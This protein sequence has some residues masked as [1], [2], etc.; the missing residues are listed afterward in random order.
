M[1]GPHHGDVAAHGGR[2]AEVVIGQAARPLEFLAHVPGGPA[3]PVDERRAGVGALVVILGRAHHGPLAVCGHRGT[4]DV[5]GG[6]ARHGLFDPDGEALAQTELL[7]V[8]RTGAAPLVVVT[9]GAEQRC[10]AADAHRAA[11]AIQGVWIG[12]EDL[13]PLAPSCVVTGEDVG[14]AC[15]GCH[16]VVTRRAHHRRSPGQGDRGAELVLGLT[17]GGCQLGLLC[18][19]RAG[20]LEDMG[21]ARVAPLVIVPRGAEQ[22]EPMAQGHAAAQGIP[23][24]HAGGGDFLLLAPAGAR[25]MEDEAGAR[26][27][28]PIIVRAGTHQGHACFQRHRATEG[29]PCRAVRAGELGL[30]R[31]GRTAPGE[32]IGRS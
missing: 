10:V 3:S 8:G 1:V 24:R 15:A 13:V 26:V 32:D 16:F 7:E 20:A 19:G 25:A 14:R 17:R 27:G 2:V 18:P 9:G 28:A 6:A 21:R 22:G 11:Q 31:P 5:V 4:E 23:G 12:G 30:L 29:V